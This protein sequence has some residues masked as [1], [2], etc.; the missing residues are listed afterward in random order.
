M[1]LLKKSKVGTATAGLTL[2]TI[3]ACTK[4]NP[5]YDPNAYCQAG[6]RKCADDG[7]VLICQK[8]ESWPS[9]DAGEPWVYHCWDGTSCE[10]G[11]CVAGSSAR[12]C[13]VQSDCDG[14]LVCTFVLGQDG[15]VSTYCLPPPNPSGQGPGRACNDGAECL[16][17]RCTRRVCF[18]PCTQSSDCTN[19]GQVCDSLDVTVDGLK[20][21]DAVRGCVP[22]K[23]DGS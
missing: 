19:P 18:E 6:A 1:A 7:T 14:N 11:R 16:S 10:A 15:K 8:D 3:L 21:Q 2:A 20:F 4:A 22:P 17:G 9:E 13:E 12:S 5:D 23:Q